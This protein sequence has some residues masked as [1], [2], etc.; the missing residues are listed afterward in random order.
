MK[1]LARD[2]Y[3]CRNCRRQESDGVAL[4]VHH[5]HYIY[6]LDPWEYKD[7]ELVTLCE[8][9]HSEVHSQFKTPVYRLDGE[10]LVEI[11]LTP[12]SRC[13]GAGWLPQFKHVQRGI[14]FR[15]HG[16]KYE[17][18]IE[19]VENYA[20]E[21]DI[22]LKDIDDGFSVLDPR[23]EGV[24]T[25]VEARVKKCRNRDGVYCQI[26]LDDGRLG[27]ACLDYSVNAD[28]GDKLD[29]NKLRYRKA[30]KKNG[31]RYMIIKGPIMS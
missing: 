18:Y 15:C 3:T 24:G 1:I 12:C 19:V 31:D 17:E 26:V 6:G 7:S 21:H 10:N 29:P 5:M 23:I 4:Q 11:Q 28:P 13:G 25:I 9:C 20:Q 14:C 8:S 16:M 22:D 30:V 27:I 2:Q